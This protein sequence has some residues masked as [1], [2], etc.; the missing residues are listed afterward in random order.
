MV[1]GVQLQDQYN[2]QNCLV[3]LMDNVYLYC[4]RKSG[5]LGNQSHYRNRLAQQCMA[6]SWYSNS[7]HLRHH[8]MLYRVMYDAQLFPVHKLLWHANSP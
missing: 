4:D 1:V 5:Y 6:L 7:N 8:K 2:N 3:R